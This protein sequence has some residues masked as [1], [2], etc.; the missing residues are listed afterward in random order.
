[1]ATPTLAPV[2]S[3][4]PRPLRSPP[5]AAR[6]HTARRWLPPS[7]DTQHEFLAPSVESV[8][9]P[10]VSIPLPLPDSIAANG[11]IYRARPSRIQLAADAFL[12]LISFAPILIDKWASAHI[13]GA[14]GHPSAGA[15]VPGEVSFVYLF[16]AHQSPDLSTTVC[17]AIYAIAIAAI[18]HV[19]S[20][21]PVGPQRPACE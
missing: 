2:H 12:K 16:S 15:Q 3:P 9:V 20:T 17:P 18:H 6:N 10:L 1:M 14:Q 19:I 13:L 7:A 11:P 21:A 8:G 5:L 4:P